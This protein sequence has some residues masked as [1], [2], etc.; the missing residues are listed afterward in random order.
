MHF[1]SQCDAHGVEWSLMMKPFQDSLSSITSAW[2]VKWSHQEQ[3]AFL[4]NSAF[5]ISISIFY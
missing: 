2:D 4:Q 3:K 5:I 1:I